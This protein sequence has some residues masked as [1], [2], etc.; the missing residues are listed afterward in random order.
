MSLENAAHI[1]SVPA[2][3]IYYFYLNLKLWLHVAFPVSN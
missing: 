1:P 2:L 3:N